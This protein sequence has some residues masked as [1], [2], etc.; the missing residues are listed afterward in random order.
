MTKEEKQNLE[1]QDIIDE[2]QEEIN[3][4]ENED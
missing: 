1:E 3:E 2:M 4:I